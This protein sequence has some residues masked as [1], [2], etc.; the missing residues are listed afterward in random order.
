MR[1]EGSELGRARGGTDGLDGELLQLPAWNP[2]NTS[3]PL[4]PPLQPEMPCRARIGGGG[5][6]CTYLCA[7]ITKYSLPLCKY[8]RRWGSGFVES[9]RLSKSGFIDW[10][11]V[12]LTLD[13][14]VMYNVHRTESSLTKIVKLS[15][16][17]AGSIDKVANCVLYIL[18]A[19]SLPSRT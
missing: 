11:L 15:P 13:D 6:G 2:T 3:I 5:E 18:R 9:L 14:P 1:P 4:Y 19:L 10:R 12:V 8:N 16:R 7:N 17:W